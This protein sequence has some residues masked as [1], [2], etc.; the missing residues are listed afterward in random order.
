MLEVGLNSAIVFAA[1]WVG[2]GTVVALCR[3]PYHPPG[4][5]LLLLLLVPL[6]PYLWIAGNPFIAVMFVAGVGSIMRWPLYYI[7]RF[8]W[9]RITGKPFVWLEEHRLKEGEANPNEPEY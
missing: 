3:R 1:C 6:I 5:F 9:A 8:T 4:A 2:M 7:G